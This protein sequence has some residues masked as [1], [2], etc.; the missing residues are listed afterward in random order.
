MKKILLI[1][2]VFIVSLSLSSC[3]KKEYLSLDDIPGYTNCFAE[4]NSK[5]NSRPVSCVNDIGQTMNMTYEHYSNELKKAQEEEKAKSIEEEPVN[6]YVICSV[7]VG[8]F[9]LDKISH[10]EDKMFLLPNEN[11]NLFYNIEKKIYLDENVL[12]IWSIRII[13]CEEQEKIE[14]TTT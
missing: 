2:L 3:R 5:F 8:Y 9:D 14:E 7:S 4:L 1:L 10:L 13:T 11:N 6:G 12:A